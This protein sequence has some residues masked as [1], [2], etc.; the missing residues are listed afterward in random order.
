METFE[1]V[2]VKSYIIKMSANNEVDAR[3]Y[4]EFFTGDIQDISSFL[5]RKEFGFEIL[6]I[7]CKVNEA[8]EAT[9][10]NEEH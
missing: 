1:V 10:I 6:N 9:R 8:F 7:D 3:N 2:L 4:C 5:D